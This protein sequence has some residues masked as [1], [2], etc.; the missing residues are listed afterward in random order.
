MTHKTRAIILK[1]IK[2][3]E[4]SIIVTAITELFGV[5]IYLVN[6]VRSSKKTNK[7][8]MYLPCS[9]LQMEVY[10]NEQKNLQRIKEAEWAHIYKEIYYDVVKN[11]VGLYIVELI[12][13]MLRQPETNADLY[14]FCE[15]ALL[16]LDKASPLVTANFSIYFSLQLAYFFGFKIN[17]LPARFYAEPL[18]FLDLNEG[19]FVLEQQ[20]SGHYIETEEAGIV[21]ELLK[22]QHPADLDQVKMNRQKRMKILLFMETYYLLHVPD[23]RRLKTLEVLQNIFD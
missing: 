10:H 7:A 15:D 22:V 18:F 20:S 3:G 8:A 19:Q 21:A 6:G 16:E 9:I 2:Y 4:T 17:D 1:T 13:N 14:H 23:F 12:G 5:Q 11:C